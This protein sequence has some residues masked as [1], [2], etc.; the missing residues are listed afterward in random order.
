[1]TSI[2]SSSDDIRESNFQSIKILIKKIATIMYADF[3][4]HVC[5]DLQPHFT[6]LLLQI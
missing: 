3:Q 4:K 6:K 1:M 2:E 5:I